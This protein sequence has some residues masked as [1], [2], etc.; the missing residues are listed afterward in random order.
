MECWRWRGASPRL[1]KSGTRGRRR[2]IVVPLAQAVVHSIVRMFPR[3]RC[4]VRPVVIAC[5][6]LPL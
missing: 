2:G 1:Q 4:S 3:A 6:C 5:A